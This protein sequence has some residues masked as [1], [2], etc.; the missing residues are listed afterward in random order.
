MFRL[1][2]VC[3]PI[4]EIQGDN[5]KKAVDVNTEKSLY[6]LFRPIEQVTVNQLSYPYIP[7]KRFADSLLIFTDGFKIHTSVDLLNK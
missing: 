3:S 4:S 2:P 6:L 1:I 7:C 5:F